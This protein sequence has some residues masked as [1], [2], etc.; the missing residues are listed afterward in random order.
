M[1]VAFT[2]CSLNYMAQAKTLAD[3]FHEYNPEWHFV[4]GLVEQS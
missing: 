3:S 4:I 1:K 2:L